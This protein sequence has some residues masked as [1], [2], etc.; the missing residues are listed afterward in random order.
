MPNALRAA[1]RLCFL[2]AVSSDQVLAHALRRPDLH[3][4]PLLQLLCGIDGGGEH[5]IQGVDDQL[6]DDRVGS[7]AGFS[8]FAAFAADELAWMAVS[9]VLPRATPD[10]GAL[11]P[12]SALVGATIAGTQAVSQLYLTDRLERAS[13]LY[14]AKRHESP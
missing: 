1:F 7:P 12:G 4:P 3:R 14:G 5:A 8:F 9:I 2:M 6:T 13:E 10:P 11:L